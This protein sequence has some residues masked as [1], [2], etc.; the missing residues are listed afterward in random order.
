[1]RRLIITLA[2]AGLLVACTTS[3]GGGESDA[4]AS[5]GTEPSAAA[6]GSAGAAASGPT[7]TASAACEEAFAPIADLEIESASDL[8]DLAEVEGTVESCESVAD[9]TAGAEGALGVEVR[10]GTADLLLRIRCED[11]SLSSAPICEELA[12][13]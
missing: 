4:D 11:P 12:S 10:A 7:G 13:S 5:L 6:S 9:W 1:M 3:D 2:V 8:G